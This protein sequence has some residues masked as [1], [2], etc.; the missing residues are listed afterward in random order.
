VPLFFKQWGDNLTLVQI[1]KDESGRLLDDREWNEF[2]QPD[3]LASAGCHWVGMQ[4]GSSSAEDSAPSSQESDHVI[5]R[6]Y[7]VPLWRDVVGE[8]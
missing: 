7:S 6:I 4:T 2:P 3:D 8:P 1:W 5:V